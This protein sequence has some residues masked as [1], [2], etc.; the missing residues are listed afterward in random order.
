MR[1][2]TAQLVQELRDLIAS[3]RAVQVEIIDQL[4]M[5]GEVVVKCDADFAVKM[6]SLPSIRTIHQ[7]IIPMGGPKGGSKP[8]KP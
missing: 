1:P 5:I 8:P 7:T 4:D 6:A 2:A 3:E